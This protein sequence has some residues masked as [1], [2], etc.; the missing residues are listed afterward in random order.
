MPPMNG[1]IVRRNDNADMV[2]INNQNATI[3]I[4]PVMKFA[5]AQDNLATS[6]E[7]LPAVEGK[8]YIIHGYILAAQQTVAT[9]CQGINLIYPDFWIG[10]NVSLDGFGMIPNQAQDLSARNMGLNLLTLPGKPVLITAAVAAPSVKV[11]RIFYTEV[12]GPW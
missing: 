9:A 11:C 5:M 2:K 7:V 8:A 4:P 1:A 6:L 3:V 10:G 12:N